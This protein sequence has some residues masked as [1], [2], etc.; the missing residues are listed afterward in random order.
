M[1]LTSFGGKKIRED[2]SN[3]RLCT[4]SSQSQSANWANTP[5]GWN[6]RPSLTS[7][8][9]PPAIS[10]SRP[11]NPAVSWAV[12]D[13]KDRI[14]LKDGWFLIY[15]GDGEFFLEHASSGLDLSPNRICT[16]PLR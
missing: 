14:T 6:S 2:L 12:F 13:G 10:P 16:F 15:G 1:P 11:I 9:P 8:W 7:T 5:P 3:S 4:Q